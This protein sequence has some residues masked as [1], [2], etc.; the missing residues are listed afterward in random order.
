MIAVIGAGLVGSAIINDLS[1][2]FEVAAFD[3]SRKAL[4]SL[5]IR[6]TYGG[7]IFSHRR[8]IEESDIVITTLPG[9]ISYA[10]VKKLLRMGKTVVDT[11][12][13]EEDPFTLDETARSHKA[14]YVP[15]AGY[16]PGATNVLAGRM[17]K[18]ER[19]NRIEILVA[20]LPVRCTDP[21]RHAVTFN[22]EGL[23][24]EYTRPA[25][26][27]KAGRVKTVDP[28]SEISSVSFSGGKY[29]AFYTDGLRTL[30]RTVSVEDMFEKTL[31]YPGHLHAMK[32]LRDFGYFSSEKV[33][34]I[35]PRRLT[36]SLF[37]RFS[38]DFRDMCLTS[39]AG[40]SERKHEY[41]NLDR[42]DKKTQT[43]SMA[44]M[45]GYSASAMARIVMEGM[46]DAK[47]VYP[48]EYFGFFEREFDAFTTLL[49]KK[50]IRFSYTET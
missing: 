26:I 13:M 34:G 32:Q 47:G 7:E 10:V 28:L 48:P 36:E 2:D 29:E 24:D 42:Y 44:R 3:R 6:K 31:R 25:R 5:D 12:F 39:V 22:V 38:T 18:K 20:G 1:S 14:L 46:V 49:R 30:L 15:D 41:T 33:E 40:F 21:F 23:I 9:S 27:V 17:Y 43:K 4:S 50:G 8:V 16:A 37:G 45:T 35:V 11:S 19:V